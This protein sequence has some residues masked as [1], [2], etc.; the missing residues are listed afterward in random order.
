LRCTT[1]QRTNPEATGGCAVVEN[2]E[3]LTKM[4]VKN[5]EES[6][7]AQYSTYSDHQKTYPCIPSRKKREGTVWAYVRTFCFE[8]AY[9][10]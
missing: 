9:S 1:H 6:S 2:S 8:E 7:G 10:Q 4:G 3:L 5:W